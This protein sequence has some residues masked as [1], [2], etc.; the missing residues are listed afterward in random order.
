M[1]HPGEPLS[2]AAGDSAQ[3]ERSIPEFPPSAGWTLRY[4][5][6]LP[7]VAPVVV[8]AIPDTA[9]ETYRV[10][11]TA[12]TT[13]A[14]TPGPYRWKALVS[15]AGERHQIGEGV[16][17]VQ[18]DPTQAHDPRSHDERALDA[19]TAVLE[20]RLGESIAEYTVGGTPVKHM[21]HSTLL[22]LQGFY[23][24]RVRMQRGGTFAVQIP[25]RLT[26]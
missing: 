14:W 19:I 23:Q 15:K 2:L 25:V 20:G 9:T 17:Q 4:Y 24:A 13:A 12:A 22:R 3:W 11:L 16:L 26:R 6:A 7:S 8:E 18:P 1:V 10:D 5:L 21:D